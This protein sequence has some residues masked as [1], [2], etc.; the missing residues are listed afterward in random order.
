[1]LVSFEIVRWLLKKNVKW[2]YIIKNIYNNGNDE[3]IRIAF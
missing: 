2:M 1:M 3:K